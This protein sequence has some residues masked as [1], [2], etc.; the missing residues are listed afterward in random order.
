MECKV[1]ITAPLTKGVKHMAFSPDGN[2]LVAA[3][4]DDDQMVA[5]FEWARPPAKPGKPVAPIAHGKSTRA[6]ILSIGF[7]PNG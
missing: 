1:L 4:M 3:A 5:V 7:N 2:Y 6:K